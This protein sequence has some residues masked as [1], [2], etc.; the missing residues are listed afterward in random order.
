MTILGGVGSIIGPVVGAI[1]ITVVKTVVSSYVDRWNSLLG[2]IFLVVI[3]F[4]PEGVVPGL[5]RLGRRLLR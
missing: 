3:V 5:R 2:A 4:M 1:I